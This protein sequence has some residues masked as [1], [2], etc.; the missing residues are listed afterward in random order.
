MGIVRFAMICDECGVRSEEYTPW[1]TCREC[2]R[3]VCKACDIAERRDEET[4]NTLCK[5][6]FEELA[7]TEFCPE[8]GEVKIID[9]NGIY[10]CLHCERATSATMEEAI[11]YEA[12]DEE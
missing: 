3:D 10:R 11:R 5:K 6:C 1:T 8:H 12:Q 4:N 2:M 9:D 7:I